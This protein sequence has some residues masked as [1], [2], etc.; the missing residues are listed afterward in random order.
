MAPKIHELS[1]L[2]VSNA[3]SKTL[4]LTLLHTHA[5]FGNYGSQLKKNSVHLLA[6]KLLP[7]KYIGKEN[8]F[9]H[10]IFQCFEKYSVY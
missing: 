1:I 9:F 5:I 7:F 10:I 4:K 2:D 3:R 8:I 6:L